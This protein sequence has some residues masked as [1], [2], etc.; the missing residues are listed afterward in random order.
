MGIPI[1]CRRNKLTDDHS[2]D[3]H[4]DTGLHDRG[5]NPPYGQTTGP[6]GD[7]FTVGRQHPH[8]HQTAQ[9]GG[10]RKQLIHAVRN[11]KRNSGQHFQQRVIT[12]TDIVTLANEAEEGIQTNNKQQGRQGAGHNDSRDIAVNNIHCFRL[13]RRS[14]RSLR[15]KAT[16]SKTGNNA[17]HHIPITGGTTPSF[18]QTSATPIRL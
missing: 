10:H 7:Q 18:T 3:Q 11:G 5:N 17:T 15:S 6:H 13:S 4:D 16:V 1:G 14:R 12:F 9:Q 8:T 2:H